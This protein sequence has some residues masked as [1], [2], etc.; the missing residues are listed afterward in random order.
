MCA[1]RKTAPRVAEPRKPSTGLKPRNRRAA[2]RWSGGRRTQ[3]TQ[4]GIETRPVV[5]TRRPRQV[6]EPRKPSTGLKLSRP[7]RGGRLGEVAEPRKPSTGLKQRGYRH[8]DLH[9]V[10][11][12]PR[13]RRTQKTQ[14][15]IETRSHVCH[16]S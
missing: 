10:L 9:A 2:R 8:H 12:R 16:T 13:R 14:H 5:A 1:L 3:K 7:R 4:H 11:R 15:G 6:A